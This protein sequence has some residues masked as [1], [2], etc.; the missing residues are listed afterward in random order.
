LRFRSGSLFFRTAL[1]L[2]L[3][4]IVFQASAL[5][6]VYETVIV[7]VAEQSADDLS[8]LV[9]LSA[10]TWVELPPA[11]RPAFEAE[12]E[13]RH[14]LT[15]TVGKAGASGPAV[16]F[17]FRHVIE[18]ALSDRIGEPVALYST[19]GDPMV[20]V[21]VPV[22]EHEL[23]VGFLPQR[24]AVQ[25]PLAAVAM[26]VLGTV[27]S[28]LTSVQLVRRLAV[29]L[30][31]AAVAARQVGAGELPQPLPETGPSELVEF[32]RRFNRMAQE[33][34][35]LLD[36]R[37]TLLAGISHDL[38]TPLT[39]LRLT[40][41]LLRERPGPE[42]IDRALADLDTMNAM[43]AGYMEL[44]RSTRLAASERCDITPLLGELAAETAVRWDGAGPCVLEVSPLAL[45]QI[46]R[47]LIQNAQRYG[48]GQ[49]A[50]LRLERTARRVRI[51]VRDFGPGIPEDQLDKVFRPFY[52][53]E[54]SRSQATGGSG[55]GLAIARQ[56]AESQGWRID[57]QNRR[58]GGLDAV[59]EMEAG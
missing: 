12:L 29:P 22:G 42:R 40:L 41:E 46:V 7:P 25:L 10:Q 23:R 55:L 47:N 37:T 6:V 16:A 4:L 39:R 1:T 9:V 17:S 54:A 49:S 30:A 58:T 13:R 8:G 14:G 2:A 18:E 43:I 24:Y 31:R 27:L 32:A 33:V 35:E 53:I 34:R 48:G 59:V 26:V 11:T 38:R 20:W 3:A 44:A 56:L 36:N 19:P 28:L 5:W 50:E 15:L 21:D 45:R 51:I 57:L 52:R